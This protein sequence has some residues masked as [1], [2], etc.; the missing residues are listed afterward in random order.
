[1]ACGKGKTLTSL[2]IKEPLKVK[3]ILVLLPSLSL[4]SKTLREWSATSQDKFN[5]ICVCSDKSVAKNDK[6]KNKMIERVDALGVPVTSNPNEINRFLLEN[7]G[8]W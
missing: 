4:L 6:T 8:E 3:R 1:M 5:W 2:W 7:N